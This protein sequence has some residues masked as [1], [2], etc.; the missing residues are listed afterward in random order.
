M[1]KCHGGRRSRP[2][3]F[4]AICVSSTAVCLF[5]HLRRIL[6]AHGAF[7]HIWR[8]SRLG[9]EL[10]CK[11]HEGPAIPGDAKWPF[12]GISRDLWRRRAPIRSVT[13]VGT[14]G[15]HDGRSA[16]LPRGGDEAERHTH[17]PAIRTPTHSSPS[18]TGCI[19]PRNRAKSGAGRGI[20]LPLDSRLALVERPPRI[21]EDSSSPHSPA[22]P[23]QLST[24]PVAR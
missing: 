19:K 4:T 21:D 22:L 12:A 8:S 13:W 2:P 6:S 23:S 17:H 14:Q 5:R 20:V 16:R 15:W 18:G 3:L 1:L 10:R 9:G 7:G 24:R 11:P